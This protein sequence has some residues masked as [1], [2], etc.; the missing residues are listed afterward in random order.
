MRLAASICLRLVLAVLVVLRRLMLLGA[1]LDAG[2]V[3]IIDTQAVARL[4]VFLYVL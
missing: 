4:G 2:C 3:E 1:R